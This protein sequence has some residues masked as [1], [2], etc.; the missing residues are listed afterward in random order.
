MAEP[1]ERLTN[2]L[3]LLLESRQPLTLQQIAAELRGQYPTNEAAL[4]GAFER[5]KSVLREVG[6]PIEQ[7]VLGGNQAGQ[8][9]Y[10]IDRR[11]YELA[12]LDLS[13]D[14]RQA[15]QL[16]VAAVRSD[17]AWGQEG[18]WKLGIGGE[19]PSRAVAATV[20]TFVALPPLHEAV[21]AKATVEFVYR[22][23]ERALDPYGLL[24]RDGY[25][26]VI[27]RDHGHDDVRTFR[28]D[29]IAGSV[30]VGVGSSFERPP[31]FDIRLVFPSDPKLLG[32]PENEITR[33]IVRIAPTRAA[34]VAGEVG[35]EAVVQR[36]DDGS[37]DVEVPCVNRDAFRSWVLGLTDHAVV[38][39]P[40][41]LRD[42]I[43]EWLTGIVGVVS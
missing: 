38:V 43:V 35:A 33:A 15:L 11:R 19:R 14:E 32:E 4:R 12:D 21:A 27:G 8:T 40:A 39:A 26:Y 31:G 30:R 13:D 24:L 10:R 22:S 29:R 5:D 42:D 37:I 18:L 2:L 17:E 20:P 23:V 6:V 25:W 3:A 16:A 34:L 7:Q 1:L 41:E 36:F 9:A 28:V